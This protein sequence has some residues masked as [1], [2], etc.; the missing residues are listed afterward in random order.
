MTYFRQEGND[1]V[2][3]TRENEQQEGRQG[4][5][6]RLLHAGEQADRRCVDNR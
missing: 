3:F 2:S 1:N 6:E 5:Y 4:C